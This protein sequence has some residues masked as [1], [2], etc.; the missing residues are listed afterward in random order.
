[1]VAPCAAS[2]T[3]EKVSSDLPCGMTGERGDLLARL[4]GGRGV[5]FDGVTARVVARQHLPA[6]RERQDPQISRAV[7][8]PC[9]CCSALLYLSDQLLHGAG[10]ELPHRLPRWSLARWQWQPLHVMGEEDRLL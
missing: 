7:L 9:C 8:W 1:M 4:A 3:R 6:R 5:L 10:G 2:P